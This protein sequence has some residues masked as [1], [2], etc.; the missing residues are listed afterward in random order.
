[1]AIIDSRGRL[2]GRVGPVVYRT[3]GNTSIAQIKAA[4]VSQTF[5]TKESAVEFGLASN[6][7][8]AIRK[9]LFPLTYTV[10]GRMI[11]RLNTAVLNC[12]KAAEG[13]KKGE[14][15]LHDGDLRYLEGFQFN[16]NSPLD[17][18]LKVRPVAELDANNRVMVHIPA[19]QQKGGLQ[20]PAHS[21]G[22]I[23]RL[24]LVAVN[25]REDYY[26]YCGYT[27]I[28]LGIGTN[29]AGH[30]WQPEAVVP[31]GSILMLTA[32]LHYLGASGM[33]EQPVSMNTKAFSPAEIVAA[34]KIPVSAVG[35]PEVQQQKD[36]AD[37][38]IMKRFPLN[39]YLGEELKRKMRKMRE[40]QEKKH[41]KQ[42]EEKQVQAKLAVF[43]MPKG[44]VALKKE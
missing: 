35:E 36:A 12:I 28:D 38:E 16:K 26:E 13:M 27:D 5:A 37:E 21:Y 34:F 33:V 17:Q 8:R 9:A 14:R 1:M 4:K 6:T 10:D 42:A 19:F 22:C 20:R 43:E 11:N 3:V 18:V 25:F 41:G 31:E 23:L 2:H 29:F 24:M 30:D 40:K 15:D 44:R 32:S 7:A 39:N